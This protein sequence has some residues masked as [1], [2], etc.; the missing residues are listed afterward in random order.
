MVTES[1]PLYMNGAG[2]KSIKFE[3][4]L[5]SG[6]STSL[7]NYALTVEYTANPAWYAVQ[8]LPYL[9][10]FPYECAEQTFSRFYANA[11]ATAIANSNP[12]IK[13]VWEQWQRADTAA[14]FS[15]LQKNEETEISTAGGNALGNGR[16]TEARQKQ[17]LG[18]L[19]NLQEWTRSQSILLKLN[20]AQLSNGGFAWFKGGADNRY[21]TQLI[22]TGIGN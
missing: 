16:E 22:A 8:S 9:M 4:L 6:S 12:G 17:N 2:S 11:I 14:L 20:E 18:L 21:I 19:F 15:N 1:I 5:Q 13:K 3:R 7:S 10:E